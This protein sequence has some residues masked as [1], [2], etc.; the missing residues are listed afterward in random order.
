M[1]YMKT[2]KQVGWEEAKEASEDEFRAFL[3][4]KKMTGLPSGY[5]IPEIFE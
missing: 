3:K 1:K 2:T 4:G 5:H